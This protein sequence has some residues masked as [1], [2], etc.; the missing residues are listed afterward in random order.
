MKPKLIFNDSMNRSTTDMQMMHHFI[1]SHPWLIQNIGKVSFIVV[2]CSGCGWASWSFFISDTC[3]TILVIHLHILRCSKAL[4][5]YYAESLQWTSAP[6]T[7]S[8]HNNFITA[9]YSFLMHTE[10]WAAILALSRWHYNWLITITL[11]ADVYASTC[12]QNKLCSQH[13]N[14]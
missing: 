6:D 2:L 12:A 11:E 9:Q 8:A 14:L 7:P 5:P 3:A 4:L 1:D 10:S 13:S